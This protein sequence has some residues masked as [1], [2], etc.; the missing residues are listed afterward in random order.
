MIKKHVIENIQKSLDE[1]TPFQIYFKNLFQSDFDLRTHKTFIFTLATN[2][3]SMT[4]QRHLLPNLNMRVFL[5][6]EPKDAEFAP[7]G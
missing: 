6:N 4:T 3:Y 1:A 2:E 7:S 5:A